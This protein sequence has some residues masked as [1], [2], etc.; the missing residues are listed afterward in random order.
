MKLYAFPNSPNCLKVLIAARELGL[1]LDI[2]NLTIERLKQPEYLAIHPMGMVPALRDGE[3]TLWESGAILQYF[4]AKEGKGTLLSNESMARA[5]TLR[6]L[7]FYT[8][9]L[10]PHIY[11]I[12]WERLVKQMFTGVAG[13]DPQRVAFA[14]EQLARCLPV[15]EAQLS[16]SDYL[17]QHYGIADIAAGVS[18]FTLGNF[19]RFDLAPYPAISRWLGRLMQ[20]EGWRAV[21]S[22]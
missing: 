9:H 19:L 6:W 16:R 8:A 2:E 4:A 7:A 3:L 14:E 10:H 15:V 13:A 11:L 22:R 18:C 5:D 17:G 12:G 1:S 21:L 20:R